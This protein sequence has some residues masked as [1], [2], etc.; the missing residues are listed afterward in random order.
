MHRHRLISAA[1]LIGFTL[2]GWCAGAAADAGK[3]QELNRALADIGAAEQMLRQKAAM[4]EDARRMLRQQ[5]EELKAEIQQ[6]RRRTNVAAFQQ[7]LQVCRID[8]N[9]RLVQR[10]F[11]YMERLEDRIGYFRTAVHA[12]DFHRRQIRDD[13]LILKT[14]NDADISGLMRQLAADLNGFTAQAEK[15]LLTASASGLR[16]LEAI[17]SDILQGK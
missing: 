2:G 7:A 16:P 1:L 12:L 6:E 4:A 9:L 11:G 15:P 5:A 10:L 17:W 14:L 3:A 8:Y 13:L